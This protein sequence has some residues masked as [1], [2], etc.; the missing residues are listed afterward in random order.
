[1]YT[2]KSQ[3][4]SRLFDTVLRKINITYGELSELVEGARLEIV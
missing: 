3:I 2:T 4:A 1:M